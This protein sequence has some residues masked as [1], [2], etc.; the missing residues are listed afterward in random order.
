MLKSAWNK[1]RGEKKKGLF[2]GEITWR[3]VSVVLAG[4][5]AATFVWEF[6]RIYQDEAAKKSAVILKV[7]LL[8][9]VILCD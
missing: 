4:L 9:N 8:Y 1:I 2:R 5:A 6:M 3:E 7:D